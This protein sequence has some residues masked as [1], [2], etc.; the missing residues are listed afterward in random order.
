[1]KRLLLPSVAG[2]GWLLMIPLSGYPMDFPTTITIDKSV[3]F[4]APDGN[5]VVVPPGDYGVDE[6][7]KQL[8]LTTLADARTVSIDARE[9]T[10]LQ[11]VDLPVAVTIAGEGE[12]S[13]LLLVVLLMPDQTSFE[14]FGSYSGVRGRGFQDRVEQF[15]ENARQAAANAVAFAQQKAR[16]AAVQVCKVALKSRPA[17][18]G[19]LAPVKAQAASILQD[20]KFKQMVQEAVQILFRDKADVIRMLIDQGKVWLDPRN[21]EQIKVLLGGERLCERPYHQTMA[22]IAQLYQGQPQPRAIFKNA[23]WTFTLAGE[24]AYFAGVQGSIG[25]VTPNLPIGIQN[26]PD[27]RQGRMQWSVGGTL[28]ADIDAKGSANMGFWL[29]PMPQEPANKF[30]LS[31]KG[32][33]DLG[34]GF[35]VEFLFGW[36]RIRDEWQ[37]KKLK[38]LIPHLSGIEVATSASVTPGPSI[39]LDIGLTRVTRLS[40]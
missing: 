7:N 24:A 13:D 23:S 5:D 32:G 2:L 19:L 21:R 40:W 17:S 11:Q 20:P 8:H 29:E 33:G 1:M 10:H 38:S 28:M 27:F 15:R 12:S 4:I 35:E 14:T 9:S 39:G 3:H 22:A 37:S 30:E 18:Q 6:V 16:E 36:D 25:I 31:V 26:L 34:A